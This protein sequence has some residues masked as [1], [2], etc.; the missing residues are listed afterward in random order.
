MITKIVIHGTCT[1]TNQST[2]ET[3]KKI[4]LIYGLNGS[5]KS[6][7][8]RLLRDAGGQEFE[9]CSIEGNEG[10]KVLVFND[11]FIREQFYEA[12][13]IRG[14]FSL[15]KQ[16]K[17]AERRI[18]SANATKSEGLEL[19]DGIA[20]TYKEARTRLESERAEIVD[21]IFGIKR[22]HAGGDRLLEFCLEGVMGNKEKLA[23]RLSGTS[24]PATEP[25]YTAKDLQEETRRLRASQGK[26]PEQAVREIHAAEFSGEDSPLLQT[27]IVGTQNSTFA[28]AINELGNSDWVRQGFDSYLNKSNPIPLACPFC[29][30]A[31]ITQQI[32]GYL[33]QYFDKA[34][35][36]Q[37][38]D[39]RELHR[40]Y[41]SA[42][43]AVPPIVEYQASMFYSDSLGALYAQLESTL[44]K[45]Q[46][47]LD[48]K[49]ESPSTVLGLE[50]TCDLISAINASISSVNRQ[51]DA[52]NAK[53]RDAT[54]ALDDIKRRFWELMRWQYD[55]SIV[56]LQSTNHK[57]VE[58]DRSY[59]T[60][61]QQVDEKV[62][63]CDAEIV[64]AQKDVI[65]TDE[66]ILKINA[67]LVKM[68]IA[69]FTI[70]KHERSDHLYELKR[71]SGRTGDFKTL[72]E[73]E[74]M[75][76]ALLYFCELCMG[77]QDPEE[78]PQKRI[79]VLDD[80]ISS[81]SHI[82]VFNV[83]R[84]VWNHFFRNNG[85]DQIFV[86]THS[87]YFFYELTEIDKERRAASQ[88]LFRIVKNANG[89]QISPMSYEEIQN[90]YH[91]YWQIINDRSAHAA[92][93]ANCMR[94]ILEYFFGFVEK[95]SFNNV[96]QKPVL[97]APHLQAFS[98]YMNRESHSFG[99]N[100]FDL[101]EFDYEIFRDGLK[102]VFEQCG[103]LEHYKKMAR[104]E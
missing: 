68:G 97:Q 31:T 12:D 82:F 22:S 70:A 42:R 80:P 59:A 36:N 21:G 27:A 96:F 89:S 98:R 28:R 53:L 20:A 15:S 102:Q 100:V 58:L 49:L 25:S 7:V 4:N 69:D 92:L 13:A 9:K 74:K 79:V 57:L 61:I 3:T 54:S 104:I 51:V 17:E 50:K 34:Y 78:A 75:V 72:S 37:L 5:G 81:L 62:K 2:L 26:P 88:S 44:Q 73:G 48:R 65:N 85:I 86:F 76:I 38:A 43:E 16:N 47:A 60:D 91:S 14:I 77:R 56:L 87:L 94:N 90:D 40:S 84:L 6:T 66:A 29:Q 46:A 23:D 45:N 39:L 52:H 83:G 18:A 99:Q 71:E 35:E 19:K 67:E 11:A 32:L 95:T 24:K 41:K 1:F 64:Q 103:Y 8:C 55:A 10:T 30:E 93:I 101:K 63:A 33:G